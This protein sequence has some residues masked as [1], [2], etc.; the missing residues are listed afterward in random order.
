M[1]VLSDRVPTLSTITSMEHVLDFLVCF[2]EHFIGHVK[3]TFAKN[4]LG[5]HAEFLTA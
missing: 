5:K 3:L 2:Q 1:P 4:N